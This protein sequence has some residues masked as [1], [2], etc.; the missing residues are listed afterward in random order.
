MG[1]MKIHPMI[2][3]GQYLSW[4]ERMRTHFGDLYEKEKPKGPDTPELQPLLMYYSY[5][6]AAFCVVLEG[7]SEIGEKDPAIDKLLHP[8]KLAILKR[9][10]NGVYHFQAD[11]FF[12]NRFTELFKSVEIIMPWLGKVRT[13]TWTFYDQWAKTH[14]Y[15]GLPKSSCE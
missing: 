1:D 7:Y 14:E 13:A 15:D 4:A 10:R 3:F 11:F 12:D 9:Y 6:L 2:A 5:W 8:D